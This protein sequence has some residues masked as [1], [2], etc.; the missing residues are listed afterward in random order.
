LDRSGE[1][2]LPR[3]KV[4]DIMQRRESLLERKEQLKT[5]DNG[6]FKKEVMNMYD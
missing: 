3:D 5:F 6:V 2:H 4:K 1:G